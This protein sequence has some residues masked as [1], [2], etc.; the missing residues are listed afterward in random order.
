MPK[1]APTWEEMSRE[2]REEVASD[3]IRENIV[4]M[5]DPQFY[6]AY[7]LAMKS[8]A[9]RTDRMRL[10]MQLLQR[11]RE[12]CDQ[13]KISK[14]MFQT[15]VGVVASS[16]DTSAYFQSLSAVYQQFMAPTRRE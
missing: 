13:R 16:L 3:T 7:A 1:E 15:A 2:Q 8:A 12:I 4:G 10:Q 11:F 14:D 5:D 9:D 6:D